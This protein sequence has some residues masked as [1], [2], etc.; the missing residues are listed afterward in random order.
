M[1]NNLPLHVKSCAG[2]DIGNS[3]TLNEDDYLERTDLQLWAVADGMGGHDAGDVASQL[4]IQNLDQF[5]LSRHIGKNIYSLTNIAQRVNTELVELAT[6]RGTEL[7][8]TTMVAFHIVGHYGTC[9]WVGDSRL[10]LLRNKRL[11]QIT[12]DHIFANEFNEFE[13]FN[14]GRDIPEDNDNAI[15]RAVGGNVTLN[16]DYLMLEVIQGDIFLLCTDGLTRDVTDSE[17]EQQIG[18]QTLKQATD[19]LIK[20]ALNREAKDNITLVAIEIL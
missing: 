7:I 19:S 5:A 18:N 11:R 16:I 17:L 20:T 14:T 3:R 4:L 9:L 12:R 1:T 13:S 15:T 8:G 6:I 10:Y 2:T